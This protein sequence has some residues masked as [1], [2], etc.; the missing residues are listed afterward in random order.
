MASLVTLEYVESPLAVLHSFLLLLKVLSKS[1]SDLLIIFVMNY[2][3][4]MS[5]HS[6]FKHSYKLTQ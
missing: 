2:F 1:L 6:Q 5:S 4:G 3:S